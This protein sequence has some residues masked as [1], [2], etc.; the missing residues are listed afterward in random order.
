MSV[1]Q[2]HVRLCVLC[3]RPDRQYQPGKACELLLL[4][5]EYRPTKEPCL[6]G[7]PASFIC[8]LRGV[9]VESRKKSISH[10]AVDTNV[11]ND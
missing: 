2:F 1:I 11:E 5:G 10:T 4:P 3:K 7:V 8:V 6:F 9:T